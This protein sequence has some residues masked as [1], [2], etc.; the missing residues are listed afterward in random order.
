MISDI[1]IKQ[2][3]VFENLVDTDGNR[4][5]IDLTKATLPERHELKK[6]SDHARAFGKRVLEINRTSPVG[7]R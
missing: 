5:T 1:Y 2:H 6:V 7:G 4:I 3:L